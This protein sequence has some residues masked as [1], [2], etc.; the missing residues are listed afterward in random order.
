MPLIKRRSKRVKVNL[1]IFVDAG[2]LNDEATLIEIS[3]EGCSLKSSM[4]L[5]TSTNLLLT[6]YRR[7][8]DGISYW[9]YTPVSAKIIYKA[10]S[11]SRGFFKYGFQFNTAI[12]ESH[13]IKSIIDN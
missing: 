9:K 12:T 5:N 1:P 11:S 13:G 2:H 4:D 7:K 10:K 3:T 6:F 8:D